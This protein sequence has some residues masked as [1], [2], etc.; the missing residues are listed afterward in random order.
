MKYL[1]TFIALPVKVENQFLLAR[2]EMMESLAKERIVWVDPQRYHVTIRFLGDTTPEA[3]EAIRFSMRDR[4]IVTG[5]TILQ[6][7]HTGNFGS[8]NRPVVIWVGFKD[9]PFLEMLREKVEAALDICGMMPSEQPF[10]PHL[11]IGRIR[12]LNDL[13]G[14]YRLMNSMKEHFYGD[15][16]AD[17]LVF[18]KSE[19]GSGGPVYTPLE[20]YLFAGQTF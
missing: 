16:L 7:G 17:R 20:E 2:K 14:F 9:S 1:R 4:I 19:P 12:R 6:L 13:Q 8:R 10:R 5:T 3:V 18:Y 11:T 15:T